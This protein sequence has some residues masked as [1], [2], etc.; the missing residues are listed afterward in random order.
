MNKLLLQQI[1]DR[2]GG[3]YYDV[4]ALSS[5]PEDVGSLPGFRPREIVRS[6]EIELW[7]RSWML[8]A[9]VLVFASEWFLR[10]RNGM[11]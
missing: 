4:N 1:A 5:L 6:S 2:T 8:A 7:N 10:K 3:R 11:L 9:V